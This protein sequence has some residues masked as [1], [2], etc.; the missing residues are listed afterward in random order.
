M[1]A[2]IPPHRQS[3]QIIRRLEREIYDARS[4]VIRLMPAD[5]QK[6]IDE[7][8]ACK[9]RTEL[10]AWR[11]RLMR[12]IIS[13]AEILP[14]HRYSGER[15]YCPLC[16]EGPSSSYEEGFSIP[17][18]LERHLDRATTGHG[19][20]VMEVIWE[21]A[22]TSKSEQIEREERRQREAEEAEAKARRAVETLWRVDQG[23]PKLINELWFSEQARD[24]ESLAVAEGRL[25]Q[26]GFK[27]SVDGNIKS[28]MEETESYIV[29]ADPRVQG[30]I[31]FKVYSKTKKRK[32]SVGA[33][34]RSFRLPDGWKNKLAD[35]Y[36]AG[37]EDVL[38]RL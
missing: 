7:F 37:L 9:T 23:A 4:T 8:Y 18:G 14:K 13:R 33:D 3:D 38:S 12:Y 24:E 5:V 11:R 19:C 30:R 34:H 29:Y 16:R 21:F 15:A 27:L 35:K 36:K 32:K 25:A 10:G 1:S 28:Y 2:R 20:S 22:H 31:E 6:V 17:L 26:I